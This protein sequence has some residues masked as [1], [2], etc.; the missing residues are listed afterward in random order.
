MSDPGQISS[1]AKNGCARC[2]TAPMLWIGQTK[3]M[4]L[5]IECEVPGNSSTWNDLVVHNAGQYHH[6]YHQKGAA[7]LTSSPPPALPL[8]CWRA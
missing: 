4:P 7:W 6:K 5:S 8:A 3:I 2:S 1:E